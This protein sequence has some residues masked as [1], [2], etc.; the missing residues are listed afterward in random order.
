MVTERGIRYYPIGLFASVMG[1]AGVT[2][3][4]KHLESLYDVSHLLSNS[5]LILTTILFLL[6]GSIFIYRLIR[7]REDIKQDF[8]HP[9]K[10]NFFAAISISLLLLSVPYIALNEFISF[11]LWGIG[12]V[13][14]LLL[15]LAILS[16]LIW[17]HSFQI[18]QFNPSW[19][20]PIVGNIVVPLAGTTHAVDDINWFFFGTGILFSIIYT[21]IFF[22]RIFFHPPL[23]EKLFPTFF[24]L[25]APPAIGLVSYMK[26]VGHLDNFAYMLYSIAFFIGLVLIFQLKKIISIPFFV[27]WWAFLFPS[28]AMTIAT[29]QMFVETEILFYKW[30]F[31]LQTTGLIVLAIYLSFKTIELATKRSLCIKE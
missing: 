20:I 11:F 3:A 23:Q 31:H 1:F 6:N 18:T 22:I 14:Q 5:F 10:M 26:I 7:F 30:F 28:A 27:S 17:T 2:M 19:F 12:T 13:L 15:T 16:K 24:I 4:I 29:I 9:V 25:M 21:T 8:N